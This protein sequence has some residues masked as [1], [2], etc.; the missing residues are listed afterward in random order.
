MGHHDDDALIIHEEAFQPGDGVNIQTIGGLVQQNDV[1]LSEQRAG[2]QHLHLLALGQG[3]HQAIEHSVV[4][5]QT[6]QELSGFGFGFPAIQLGKLRFQLCGTVAVLF[7]KVLF[8]IEGILFLEHFIQPGIALQNGL[9]NGKLL[10]GKVI[11]LQNRHTALGVDHHFALAGFQLTG[12]ELEKCGFT[13]AVGADHTIAVAG[14]EQ[15]VD[16]GKQVLAAEIQAKIRYS[17]HLWESSYSSQKNQVQK[18]SAPDYIMFFP[19][20]QTASKIPDDYPKKAS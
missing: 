15:Q 2:Q 19:G 11:L 14:L 9:K 13:R 5:T 12:K 20:G 8:C 16:M 1:R 17:N 10:I 7:G 4:Q 6:L 3:A 18:N